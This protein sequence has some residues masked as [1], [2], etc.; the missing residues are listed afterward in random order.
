MPF[1]SGA[2]NRVWK[3]PRRACRASR[4]PGGI[5]LTIHA[6]TPL[7]IGG[8]GKA[9]AGGAQCLLSGR[10]HPGGY[11]HRSGD[12][13]TQLVD[14][15]T[16]ASKIAGEPPRFRIAS[17]AGQGTRRVI[18]V[19][20]TLGQRPLRHIARGGRITAAWNRRAAAGCRSGCFGRSSPRPSGG[21]ASEG[22]PSPAPSPLAAREGRS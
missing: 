8:S 1:G 19:P 13:G 11:L 6:R 4:P 2:G 22:P 17:Q 18:C 9:L 3:K 20:P 12:D 10:C 16:V 7:D 5:P 15:A 21:K 14:E